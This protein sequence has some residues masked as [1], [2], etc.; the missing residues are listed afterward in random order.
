MELSLASKLLGRAAREVPI[1]EGN[2]FIANNKVSEFLPRSWRFKSA[3]KCLSLPFASIRTGPQCTPM[4]YL[5]GVSTILPKRAVNLPLPEHS[6]LPRANMR[7]KLAVCSSLGDPDH[8]MRLMPRASSTVTSSRPGFRI[9]ETHHGPAL[10]HGGR[11]RSQ[12]VLVTIT[13]RTA[14]VSGR[15][16][17]MVRILTSTQGGSR[18]RRSKSLYLGSERRGSSMGSTLRLMRPSSALTN[19]GCRYACSSQ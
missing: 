3:N 1:L 7:R 14:K 9:G 13:S 11:P 4:P 2:Q 19:S 8:R 18:T 17:A 10:R 15:V 12:A 5:N 6:A 16:L